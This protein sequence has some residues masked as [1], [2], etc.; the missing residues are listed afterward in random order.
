MPHSFWGGEAFGVRY[1]AAAFKR[2]LEKQ[3]LWAVFKSG[4]MLLHSEGALGA[5][6]LTNHGWRKQSLHGSFF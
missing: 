5:R 1:L 3:A 2:T 4:S 6:I